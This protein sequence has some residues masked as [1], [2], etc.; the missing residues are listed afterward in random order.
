M[1]PSDADSQELYDPNQNRWRRF[2]VLAELPYL[3]VLKLAK[4][5]LDLFER[6]VKLD[7]R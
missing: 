2:L 5:L 3:V 6:G 7:R 4:Q 1:P